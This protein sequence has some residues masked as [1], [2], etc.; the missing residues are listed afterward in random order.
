MFMTHV[1]FYHLTKSRI[2][3]ALPRLLER[4]LESGKRALVRAP[5]A[6]R[7]KLL[8]SALWTHYNDSWLPHG[9][10][11][12]GYAKDQPI[13]LSVDN[14][15]LNKATFI[16]LVDGAETKDLAIYERCFDLFDGRKEKSLDSARKRWRLLREAG[17]DMHYW[18][19][20]EQGIWKEE[21][22]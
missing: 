16:F 2:E 3:E 12:D 9:I 1:A 15:N 19:Q 5:S 18:H 8:S 20:N 10:E 21:G 14:E 7:L 11:K 6:D 4:T 17:H 22:E 13:W